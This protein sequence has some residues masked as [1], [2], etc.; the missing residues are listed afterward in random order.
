MPNHCSNETTIHGDP[1]DLDRFIKAVGP[2]GIAKSLVPM[3]EEIADTPDAYGGTEE[4]KA[5][6]EA[7]QAENLEKYGARTWYDWAINN[8]GT[9]WGDYDL[10]LDRTS[11]DRLIAYYVTAWGP[12][13]EALRH[14]SG[15]F[16]NLTFL[17]TYDEPGM[18]FC[19]AAAHHRGKVVAHPIAENDDYPPYGDEDEYEEF[20]EEVEELRGTLADMAN[21]ALERHVAKESAEISD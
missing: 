10:I 5:A 11:D 7:K 16:P 19:G 21:A 9:K 17:T 3:P 8:W 20:M 1:S 14:I 15:L 18:C 2:D 6:R 12:M 4:E 13:L